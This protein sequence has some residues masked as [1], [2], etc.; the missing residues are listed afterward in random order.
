MASIRAHGSTQVLSTA[1]TLAGLRT[2]SLAAAVLIACCGSQPP[3][4]QTAAEL[5]AC[6]QQY[7]PASRDPIPPTGQGA[8]FQR[9]VTY[10]VPCEALTSAGDQRWSMLVVAADDK[11]IRVYFVGGLMSERCDL[12]RKVNLAEDPNTVTITLEAGA[13]PTLSRAAICSAVGQSYVTEVTLLQ[14]LG[15][16]TLTGPNNQGEIHHL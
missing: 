15:S 9:D 7:H 16:R 14:K 1:S 10:A 4:P 2:I 6:L 11:T 12:L 3:G 8:R 13:D 5:N